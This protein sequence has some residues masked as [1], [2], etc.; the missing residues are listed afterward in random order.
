MIAG[1][2]SRIAATLL[3]AFFAATASADNS[4]PI[5]EG[6]IPATHAQVASSPRTPL[7]P[8]VQVSPAAPEVTSPRQAAAARPRVES[9]PSPFT[10]AKVAPVALLAFVTVLGLVITF[11]SLRKDIKS[12]RVV[13]RQRMHRTRSHP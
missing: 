1:I 5:H 2:T 13:Y 7:A 12:R 9:E 3:A 10:L 8:R 6:R 4:P 11:R